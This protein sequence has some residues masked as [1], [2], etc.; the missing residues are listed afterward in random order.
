[1]GVQ[2]PRE[3]RGLLCGMS[4]YV[5][6]CFKYARRECSGVSS[7]ATNVIRTKSQLIRLARMCSNVDYF[8]YRN[9]FLT[10]KL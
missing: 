1:M 8:N 9:L 2:L 3:A 7:Q 5:L 4:L 6:T 10:A